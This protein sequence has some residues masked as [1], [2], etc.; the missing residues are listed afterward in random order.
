MIQHELLIMAQI[1]DDDHLQEH[2]ALKIVGLCLC[3]VCSPFMKRNI[4]CSVGDIIKSDNTSLFEH[5]ACA[6]FLFFFS[7]FNNCARYWA[8]SYNTR[9]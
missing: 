4:L 9:G 7:L 5:Q 6:I 3:A 8:R 2:C 1:L